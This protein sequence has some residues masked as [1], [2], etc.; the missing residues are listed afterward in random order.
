MI[1]G[2][3]FGLKLPKT[4]QDGP[5][6]KSKRAKMTITNHLEHMHVNHLFT[7]L[8]EHQASQVSP[9]TAKK[10]PKMAPDGLQGPLNKKRVQ[11]VIDFLAKSDP[12]NCPNSGPK[13]VQK[14]A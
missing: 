6:K 1:L 4:S 7:M 5:P 8:L 13:S 12:R 10:P 9:K 14:L 2:P 3:I 11:F